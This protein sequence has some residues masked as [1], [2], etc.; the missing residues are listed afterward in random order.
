M[1][2]LIIKILVFIVNFVL[3]A[4][5]ILLIVFGGI[6]LGSPVTIVNLLDL[7]PGVAVVTA[8]YDVTFMFEGVAIFMIVLGCLLFFFG[9]IGCHGAFRMHKRMIM[10]Y[11][12]MLILAVLTE[13]ALIIYCAV[14]PPT[15][16]T[17]V[18]TGLETSLVT[19]FEPVTI[20]N[21][22][23]IYSPN[24]TQAAWEELQSQSHCCGS[25]NYT[26]YTTFSWQGTEYAGDLVPPTCCVSTQP[27][28]QNVTNTNQFVFFSSLSH[29]IS[30]SWCSNFLSN[31]DPGLLVQCHKY[32]LA[33]QLHSD[34]YFILSHWS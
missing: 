5:G 23:I 3:W 12:I 22:A 29:S 27:L 18:Q 30:W 15:I 28:G 8:V 4:A 10:N 13:I 16:N 6:A 26:E 20:S 32:G 9:G 33:V 19:D 24:A 17:A 21:G 14:Y 31:M 25:L 34:H 1:D 11:W 7:I 2:H